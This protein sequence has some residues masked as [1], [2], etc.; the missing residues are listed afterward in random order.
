MGSTCHQPARQGNERQTSCVQDHLQQPAVVREPEAADKQVKL[1]KKKDRGEGR[2]VGR[3]S[4]ERG[5]DGIPRRRIC[6]GR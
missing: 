6:T 5:E 2:D 1:D 4:Q 3:W